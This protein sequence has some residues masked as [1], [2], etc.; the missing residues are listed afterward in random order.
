MGL[1]DSADRGALKKKPKRVG[2]CSCRAHKT[3][4]GWKRGPHVA[5]KDPKV[6]NDDEDTCDGTDLVTNL[7]T[8][9]KAHRLVGFD[10][11]LSA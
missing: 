10:D 4:C 11:K 6:A 3:L 5:K 7:V 2:D 9:K 1:H 8:N